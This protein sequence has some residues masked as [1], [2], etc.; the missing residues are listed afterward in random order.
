MLPLRVEHTNSAGSAIAVMSKDP[1]REPN[2]STTTPEMSANTTGARKPFPLWAKIAFPVAGVVVLALALGLGLGLGL[3]HHHSS[4][5]STSGANATAVASHY[6]SIWSYGASPPVY[7]ARTYYSGPPAPVPTISEANNRAANGTGAQEWAAAYNSAQALVANMTNLEKNNLTIGFD[8]SYTGCAGV[9]G[10]VPRFGFPG[11]CLQDGP[12]GVRGTDLVTSFPAGIHLGASWNTTLV[13]DVATYM[14]AEFKAKGVNIALGPVV[15]P[16]GRTAQGGRNWEG[17]TNDPYL[18]GALVTQSV[19]GLQQSVIASVKHWVAYEQETNRNPSGLIASV[20]SN[21][22][23]RT[24]HELYMWPFQDAVRAGVACVMCSYNR[25]NDSYACQNSK[26]MNGLLKTELAFQ[27]FVV[28]D[29][30]G[31]HT[32]IA[33]AAAGLDMAMPNSFSLW[34]PDILSEAISNGSLP[35]SRLDDMA[36]RILAAWYQLG[37]NSSSYPGLGIGMPPDLTK[38]HQRVDSRNVSQSKSTVFQAAVEGHVLVKNVDYALPLNKP[39]LLSLFGYD[40]MA[41][42]AY[43]P[44]PSAG[45]FRYLFGYE[46]LNMTDNDLIGIM[47]GGTEAPTTA[48]LGTIVVGG[49]SGSNTPGYISSP[50]D[51]FAQQAYED[52]TYLL[53]NFNTI[54]PDVET[55]SDACIIFLNQFSSEG[56]DRSNLTDPA[57]DQLV[58]NVASNCNNTIVVIHNAGIRIVDA[59][60]DHPNVTAVIYAHLPGQDSGRALIEVMYGNQ[61]PSGRLPYTVAH[62]ESDYGQL[63]SPAGPGSAGSSEQYFPQSN[64]TEGLYI[65]YRYFIAQNIT[66]RF[67]FGYGLTYVNF[68]YSLPSNNTLAYVVNNA[69]TGN[70]PPNPTNIVSGGIASLY[71]VIAAVDCQITNTGTGPAAEVAQLYVGIPNSPAKQLRGFSKVMVSANNTEPVHLELTRR[72]LSIWDVVQQSWVLQNG[73]YQIYV[74]GNVLDTPLQSNFTI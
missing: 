53:W 36:T 16:L 39:V 48:Q 18:A 66:P 14:G 35:Q 30:G 51:A 4:S 58:L 10:G 34:A 17:Y 28:S 40:G 55:D 54:N 59:W 38:P 29:W 13:Y 33:S 61:S 15:G 12:A 19:A 43:D 5:N 64:F 25:V 52:G 65:D 46:S 20:S 42:P 50:Y 57:S 44:T 2:G 24:M 41:P 23:D 37:Q 67:P 32:G 47:G 27:G 74:G 6:E 69:S 49:G 9:S 56:S 62:Q 70:L 21:L 7:P 1:L 73:T 45:D 68:T 26:I 11:F 71:D 60:I 3:K 8:V 31:Q 63:L 22:D 72:D